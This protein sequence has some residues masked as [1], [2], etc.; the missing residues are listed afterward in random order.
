V[1]PGPTPRTG[2]APYPGIGV[3][4]GIVSALLAALV[5][6]IGARAV[7][8]GGVTPFRTAA[9]SASGGILLV[10][11]VYVI[12]TFGM[13]REFNRDISIGPFVVGLA[14]AIAV[15]ASRRLRPAV[16]AEPFTAAAGRIAEREIARVQWETVHE[17]NGPAHDIGPA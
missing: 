7:G 15:V 5:A 4:Y 14:G 9:I 12:L 3:G 2:G 13:D 6:V 10:V 8:L 1:R 11:V 17:A 16:T